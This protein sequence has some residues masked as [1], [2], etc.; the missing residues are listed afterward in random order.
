LKVGMRTGLKKSDTSPP[1][2]VRKKNR[3]N[4]TLGSGRARREG[5]EKKRVPDKV[6]LYREIKEKMLWERT[7][8]GTQGRKGK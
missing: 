7:V 1:V 8:G 4:T 5:G 6:T 2:L 3:G